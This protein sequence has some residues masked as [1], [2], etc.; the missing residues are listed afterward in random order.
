MR[1]WRVRSATP[2][3]APVLPASEREALSALVEGMVVEVLR[4]SGTLEATVETIRETPGSYPR[5][6]LVGILVPTG[7]AHLR[8]MAGRGMVQLAGV[9]ERDGSTV[10]FVP[11]SAELVQRR[12][13]VR[14]P[15]LLEADVTLRGETVSVETLN[16]SASGMKIRCD[17]P[18]QFT[19][20]DQVRV[21]LHVEEGCSVNLQGAVVRVDPPRHVTFEFTDASEKDED[22]LCKLVLSRLSG[23]LPR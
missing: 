22:V 16:V 23:L 14:A 8:A 15:L 17:D 21:L 12:T 20:G 5:I 11:S 13:F 7:E 10:T 3:P 6:G 2:R 9:L 19:P 18:R 4:P 1:S